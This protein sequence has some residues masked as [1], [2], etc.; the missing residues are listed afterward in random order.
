MPK[1]PAARYGHSFHLFREFLVL[2]GGSNTYNME[3]KKR[4][5][6]DDILL[7]DIHKDRWLD[8]IIHKNDD[9][10]C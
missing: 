10:L 7:Y 6:F 9:S 8:P 4:E 5:T 1:M 2:F 3:I